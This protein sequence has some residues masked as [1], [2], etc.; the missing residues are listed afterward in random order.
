MVEDYSCHLEG[1]RADSA[2]DE[3]ADARAAGRGGEEEVRKHVDSGGHQD[4]RHKEL[5]NRKEKRKRRSVDGM[6]GVAPPPKKEMAG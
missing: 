1:R 2:D 6:L 5:M 3:T 4:G